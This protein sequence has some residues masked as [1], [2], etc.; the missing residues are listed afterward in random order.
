MGERNVFSKKT[1]EQDIIASEKE[2][3]ILSVIY[4][5]TAFLSLLI[6]SLAT[7]FYLNVLYFDTF[8]VLA[9]GFS[10]GG[11]FITLIHSYEEKIYIKLF[12]D[13]K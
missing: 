3:V 12:G 6:I 9:I 13:N 10:I 1:G 2:T 7:S 8:L 4:T 5:A 11:I